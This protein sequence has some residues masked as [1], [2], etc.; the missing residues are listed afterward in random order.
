L[1]GGAGAD[2]MLDFS[3]ASIMQGGDGNDGLYAWGGNA[4]L[5]GGKGNDNCTTLS[6]SRVIA[7]NRGDGNDTLWDYSGARTT[8]SLGNGITYADMGLT[9][10]GNDLVLGT[11]AGESIAFKDWYA[12]T[13]SHTAFNLQAIAESMTGYIPGGA[14]ALLN[15]KIETFDFLGM[16][17]AFDAARVANPELTAWSLTNALA[18]FHLSGSDTEALGGDLAYQYG[19]SGNLSVVGLTAAQSIVSDPMFASSA[20]AL[21][22]LASLQE[23]AVRLM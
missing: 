23:G 15:N 20:Q 9:K 13:A 19:K 1:Q 3:G 8:V 7:F 16:V 5:V 18:D 4:M 22:P 12:A 21:K 6:G 10:T 2:F 14:N 17:S 11:G